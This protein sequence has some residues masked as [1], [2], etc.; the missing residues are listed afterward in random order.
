MIG[1][2]LCLCL[3]MMLVAG[4]T[5]GPDYARPNAREP[6]AFRGEADAAAQASLGDLPWWNVFQ[7]ETL[8]GLI[9]TA[10]AN[11]YDLRVAVT[12]V[13]QARAITVQTHAQVFPQVNYGFDA[14]RGRNTFLGNATASI[15]GASGGRSRTMNSF[16]SLLDASWEV[17]LWGRIR[18]LDESAQAQLLASEEARRGVLVTLVGD[19]AQ[20]YYELLEL[21]LEL[22]I[23]HH[24]TDA[25]TLSLNLFQE[26]FEG[27]VG[28]RLETSRAE[29]SLASTAATIPDLER[30][31]RIKENQIC[32]LLGRPPGPIDR[33]AT[34][35]DQATPPDVPAGLPSALIERRPDVR[36]AEQ[37]ARS[38]NANVGA[39]IADFFPRIE[40]T[41][42]TGGASTDLAKLAS[43][44]ASLWSAGL[45][46]ST[47]I[48]EGGR[49]VGQ[50][51]G[52]QATWDQSV[53]LYRQTALT[54]FKEVAD[55]LTSRDKLKEILT[56]QAQAVKAYQEAVGLALDR[57]TFGKANYY[58]VIEAQQQLFAAQNALAQTRRD[59]FLAIVQLYKALGGG[60]K[61]V[62]PPPPQT[63]GTDRT[64]PI[65]GVP[66]RLAS[67]P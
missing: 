6:E 64:A 58:E 54:A 42:R 55:S 31:I 2:L 17:D 38:A 20:A 61:V 47:P 46:I 40:L 39:A 60:W 19:V 36:Q 21:D 56:R 66:L 16:L 12:R 8:E 49:L 14:A 33:S 34:L 35:L 53:L 63:A 15:G 43:R 23:A 62:E 65:A 67:E 28:T 48:F 25:F 4:C 41:A 22:D 29:A 24:T 37:L 13:E 50:Y 45:N 3:T 1:H 51:E 30:Q 52:A 32:V 44:S 18:R 57:Y 27:G 26:R 7:D 10:V 9:Q 11:N 5:L 59:Q